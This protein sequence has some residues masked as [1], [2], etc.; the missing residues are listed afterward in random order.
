MLRPNRGD[1]ACVV[2]ENDYVREHVSAA[3]PSRCTSPRGDRLRQGTSRSLLYVAITRGQH[4]NV[5]YI[6]ERS[7][8]AGEFDHEE[9]LPERVRCLLNIRTSA[10]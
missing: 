4:A 2:F 8:E 6:Y 10:T 9:A 7:A 1:E 3:T 5:A